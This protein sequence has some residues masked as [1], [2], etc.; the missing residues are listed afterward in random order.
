MEVIL[1]IVIR[2]LAILMVF[3][4]ILPLI[5]N[6][7]W[8][9]R[10]F[11]FPRL[12]KWVINLVIICIFFAYFK[13]FQIIDIILLVLLS[14]SIIFLSYQI[15]PY[16]VF[17]P[18][19][20]SRVEE[21]NRNNLRLLISNVYQYN[22]KYGKLIKLISKNDPDIIL[23]V[24]TS[25]DWREAMD[26]AIGDQYTERVLEDQENTY[27][28][29]LFSKLKLENTQVNH[30]IK[31][32]IPSIETTVVLGYNRIKLFCLHPEPPVPSE[33]AWATDRD[34]EILIVGKKAV[35][36]SLPVIVAGD[37]N[38]VAWSHTTEL[39]LKTSDLLDPRRGRGFYNTFN[40]KYPLLRWPLDHIF[41]S[42]HFQLV[43]LKTL[44]SINS[45]HFPVLVDLALT[46]KYD[47]EN[48]LQLDYE[49]KKEVQEKIEKA[50]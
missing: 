36:E 22:K 6:D 1:T 32:E 8:T 3:A 34:A 49:E 48:N 25:A 5:R 11:E 50:E 17:S 2:V 12:Q 37:L 9:F 41:C 15:Y 47:E 7:F 46:F 30:L 18:I 43:K 44:P 4:T 40:A 42:H 31:N 20:L 28:M 24:E 27:G 16:T 45:D 29:L 14:A 23:L 38:D 10:V 33:N 19:Q 35:K 21:D 26:K 39:F 13:D